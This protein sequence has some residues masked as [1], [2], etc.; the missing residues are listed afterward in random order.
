MKPPPPTDTSPVGTL[1][2]DESRGDFSQRDETVLAIML[3]QRMADLKQAIVTLGSI[4]AQ[5]GV[6]V[7]T[8][9]ERRAL[10]AILAREV[11]YAEASRKQPV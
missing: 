7:L 8:D 5:R 2:P 9:E 10:V 11:K 4:A 3:A 1:P 6:V